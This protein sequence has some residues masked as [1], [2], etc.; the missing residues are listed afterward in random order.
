MWPLFSLHHQQHVLRHTVC[1]M[2]WHVVAIKYYCS[3]SWPLQRGGVERIWNVVHFL[4]FTTKKKRQCFWLWIGSWRVFLSLYLNWKGWCN[5]VSRR[6][7]CPLC[8]SAEQ[9]DISS[10]C[11]I[12]CF[13]FDEKRFY[14]YQRKESIFFTRQLL[15]LRRI[16]SFVQGHLSG[17]M[18]AAKG[19][20]TR[21]FYTSR[22]TGSL[23]A[24]PPWCSKQTYKGK[25]TRW[26]VIPGPT[27]NRGRASV[28]GMYPSPLWSSRQVLPHLSCCCFLW[29][30]LGKETQMGSLMPPGY[31]Y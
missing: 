30:R 10:T 21:A 1:C 25:A 14:D 23:L 29:F 28:A 22:R 9:K 4:F 11:L 18:L 19:A 12:C 7:L 2:G 5:D 6:G 8:Y 27:A 3:N 24:A 26:K 16:H 17:V 31:C 15:E 13:T 20:Q